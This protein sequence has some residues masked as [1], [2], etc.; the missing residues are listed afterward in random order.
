MR[1]VV[2]SL[3]CLTNVGVASAQEPA[4]RLRIEVRSE[5]GPVH[6]DIGVANRTGFGSHFDPESCRRFLRRRDSRI[7]ETQQ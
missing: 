7:R 2:V 4:A 3:L 6:D 5:A 1:G